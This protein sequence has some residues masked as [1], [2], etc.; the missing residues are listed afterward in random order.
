MLSVSA[1]LLCLPQN[2]NQGLSAHREANARPAAW[3]ATLDPE[4][5][6]RGRRWCAGTRGSELQQKPGAR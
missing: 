3:I 1:N 6:L 4:E 2:T 5:A